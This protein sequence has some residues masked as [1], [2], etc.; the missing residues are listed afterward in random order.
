LTIPQTTSRNIKAGALAEVSQQTPDLP[1]FV[2]T[3]LVKSFSFQRQLIEN[4]L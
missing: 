4:L 1:I 3:W 2:L